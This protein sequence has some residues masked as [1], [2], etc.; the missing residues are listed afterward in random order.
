MVAQHVHDKWD[1]TLDGCI[2]TG[3]LLTTFGWSKELY[4]KSVVQS[5]HWGDDWELAFLAK[6]RLRVFTDRSK[7][8]LRVF[9]DNKDHWQQFAEYGTEGPICRLLFTPSRPSPHY[10]LIEVREVW[11]RECQDKEEE[12]EAATVK[13]KAMTQQKRNKRRKRK[14]EGPRPDR[15]QENKRCGATEPSPL[16]LRWTMQNIWTS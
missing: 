9:T 11:E 6:Q 1:E 8:R 16:T 3:Q 2:T 10:D 15:Q 14:R 4:Q 5:S 7:Q 13:Q 12:A